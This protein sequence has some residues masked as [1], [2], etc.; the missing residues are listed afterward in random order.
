VRCVGDAASLLGSMAAP[1]WSAEIEDTGPGRVRVRFRSD[2]GDARIEVRCSAGT[3]IPTV[4][5]D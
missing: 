4:D 3:A 2:D 5:E 1:G